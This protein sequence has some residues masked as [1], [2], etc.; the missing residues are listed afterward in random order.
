MLISP[1]TNCNEKIFKIVNSVKWF[2][3][4][5]KTEEK[6]LTKMGGGKITMKVEFYI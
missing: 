4:T 3:F 5:P 6:A 2:L 1:N